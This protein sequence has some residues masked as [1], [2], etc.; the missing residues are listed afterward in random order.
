MINDFLWSLWRP[1]IHYGPKLPELL[2]TILLGYIAVLVIT[3]LVRR[4]FRLLK[5][6][7][8]LAGLLST[9][10]TTLLWVL[11]F[12][13]IAR[14]AGLSNLALTI[15]GSVIVIGLALANGASSLTADIIAGLFLAKDP[16]FEVGYLVKIGDIEGV[17]R[18][19]DLRKVR[20]R[21]LKGKLHVLPNSF[22][23]KTTFVVLNREE[24]QIDS[25]SSKR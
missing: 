10:M 24:N 7:R 23:D 4:A 20:I 18:K 11:L 2:I 15:S 22:V 13:E 5:I 9:I 6:S 16:D 19:V 1:I 21:D 25:K 12:S 17:I 8:T 3:F 14:Q